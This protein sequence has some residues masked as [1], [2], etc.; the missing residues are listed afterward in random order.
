MLEQKKTQKGT[1]VSAGYPSIEALINTEDFDGVNSAF[2][3]AYNS[4]AEQARTKRGL[5]KSRE[6]KKAMH[7][8]ELVMGLFKELLEI[9][10]K[11]QQMLKSSA[12]KKV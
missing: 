4:L 11:I 6:A 8:I 1:E 2:E 10:Y 7:A 3:I 9:K 5:K 12:A